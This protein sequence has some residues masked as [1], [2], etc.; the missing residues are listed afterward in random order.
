MGCRQS[1]PVKDEARQRS[2]L[3]E[4]DIRKSE[5][6]MKQEIKLLFLGAGGELQDLCYHLRCVYD[7]SW[8]W[9]VRVFRIRQ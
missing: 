1:A 9:L 6:E 4:K 7:S 8:L 3:I 2:D 5:K